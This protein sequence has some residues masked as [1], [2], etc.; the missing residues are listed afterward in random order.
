MSTPDL[1]AAP[2]ADCAVLLSEYGEGSSSVALPATDRPTPRPP[3]ASPSSCILASKGSGVSAP[4]VVSRPVTYSLLLVAVRQYD[5]SLSTQSH[6]TGC[7][8]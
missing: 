3:T 7:G 6:G 5:N 1:E 8:G 4:A 2:S